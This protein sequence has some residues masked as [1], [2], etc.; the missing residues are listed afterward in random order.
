MV[1]VVGVGANSVDYVYR[2]PQFPQP[3]SPS[4]KLRIA[5][6]L[7]TCGGQ[8]ATALCT[9]AAM[10][11]RTAYLGTF[12]HDPNGERIRGELAGRGVDVAHASI[13]DAVNPFAVILLDERGERV[14]LWHRGS[15][16]ALRPG[17]LDAPLV[18]SARLLHVDDVDEDAA[19]EAARI[20]R[21]AGLPVTSDIEHVT[22]R[23]EELVAAVTVPILAERVPEALTGERDVERALRKLRKVRS[24]VRLK[25]DA[26]Y[27]E[28]LV[29][30]T[31]GPRGAMLLAG[32]RLLHEPAHEVSVIDTTGAGDIFRGAFIVALLRGDSPEQILRFANAAAALSC[33]RIGAIASVPTVEDTMSLTRL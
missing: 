33:T 20:A 6:H 29:S 25:P 13:R 4:A 21:D 16:L 19:I 1:D 11:L 31:L 17:E 26:T 32:D 2:L 24:Q 23:T 14:V 28:G 9:C 22:A 15:G 30:V 27:A 18:R 10:G 3:D 12:G 5:D 7:V 8:T